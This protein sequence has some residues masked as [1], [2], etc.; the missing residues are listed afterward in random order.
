MLT[1]VLGEA[2]LSPRPAFEI[3]ISNSRGVKI[4]CITANTFCCTNSLSTA[5]AIETELRKQFQAFYGDC[6]EL[7]QSDLQLVFFDRITC[8]G[9]FRDGSASRIVEYALKDPKASKIP[10]TRERTYGISGRFIGGTIGYP[11]LQGRTLCLEILCP[12]SSSPAIVEISVYPTPLSTK[13]VARAAYHHGEAIPDTWQMAFDPANPEG[14]FEENRTGLTRQ[15]SLTMIRKKADAGGEI[16]VVFD[17]RELSNRKIGEISSACRAEHFGKPYGDL[18][19]VAWKTHRALTREYP[20]PGPL[21]MFK[22][23]V[24]N[25]KELLSLMRGSWREYIQI[26][27]KY[28]F[29]LIQTQP[30]MAAQKPC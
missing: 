4:S 29:S 20:T 15:D 27:E 3:K 17:D 10:I 24:I 21:W 26:P 6:P 22:V 7:T 12:P 9:Q 13:A 8:Y 19:I 1:R 25:L 5:S 23:P 16:Y 2:S 14:G 28:P 18:Q 11:P 30:N